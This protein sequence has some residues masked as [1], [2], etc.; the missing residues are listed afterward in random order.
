MAIAHIHIGTNQGDLA[1]N[2]RTAIDKLRSKGN[3]L[4]KSHLYETE[5]WGKVDQPNYYNMA[6]TYET[7][8]DPYALL[9]LVNEIEDELGRVRKEK[10]GER[11][12]DLDVITYDDKVISDE[13]L[14]IPH[15]HMAER[16]FVLVPMIEIAGEWIHPVKDKTIDELYIECLDTCDVILLDKTI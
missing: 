7:K 2:L 10:W 1:N 8:L 14:T 3:I 16:N 11:I 4:D 15:K 12:I 6:V 5:A 9:Q 13:K